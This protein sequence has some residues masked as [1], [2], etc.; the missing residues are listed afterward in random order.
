MAKDYLDKFPLQDNYQGLIDA[1][2][3]ELYILEGDMDQAKKHLKRSMSSNH[4]EWGVYV[5]YK[6]HL[7]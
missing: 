1:Y 6:Y 4:K 2:R 3:A 7:D 5:K